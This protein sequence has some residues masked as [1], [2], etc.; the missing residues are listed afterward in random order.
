MLSIKNK[1]KYVLLQL[2]I[3]THNCIDKNYIHN[4]SQSVRP[5]IPIYK[6]LFHSTLKNKNFGKLESFQLRY[7]GAF[8]PGILKYNLISK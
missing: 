5:P 6:L 3:S 8:K 1:V 7:F 2:N 4:K